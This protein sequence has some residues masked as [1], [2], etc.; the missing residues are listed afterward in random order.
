MA[1]SSDYERNVFLN[2]PF[3]GL[4]Q[5]MF[6]AITFAVFAC[7]FLVRCA[8]ES[9]DSGKV[10]IEKIF[11]IVED[12]RFGINDL[13]R[14]ALDPATKLPRFNMPFEL[15]LFLGARRYGQGRQKEK[16]CLILDREKYR[17][18]AFLSDISGQDIREHE[19]DP[20]VAI[21]TVRNWLRSHSSRPDIPGGKLIGEQYRN[22]RAELPQMCRDA[23]ISEDEITFVDYTELVFL[24]L[25]K[26]P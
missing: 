8:L 6:E 1:A 21:R 25:K 5:E 13:S 9:E 24:W 2:C 12:C 15:G 7:G 16:R 4:Y 14:T 18:R 17:Y 22:F 23:R 26:H 10:R 3:D 20:A 19:D 11:E